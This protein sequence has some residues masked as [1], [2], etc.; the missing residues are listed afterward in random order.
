MKIVPFQVGDR[1]SRAA[2]R[3]AG[4]ASRLARQ[5]PERATARSDINVVRVDSQSAS[6]VFVA[7]L[8]LT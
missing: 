1:A 2:P 3:L 5:P 7:A 8:N 4:V 6:M